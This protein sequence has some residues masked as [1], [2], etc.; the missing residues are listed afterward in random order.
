[1]MGDR[2]V[3]VTKIRDRLYQCEVSV[4]L[5]LAKVYKEKEKP[6]DRFK[7]LKIL[8]DVIELTAKDADEG[9]AALETMWGVIDKL[10]PVTK[11][12]DPTPVVSS[13]KRE[14]KLSGQI[15]DSKTQMGFVSL[16]RQIETAIAKK[17]TETEII[18]AILKA[19]QPGSN[20]RSY[21][22]CRRDIDLAQV[23]QIIRAHY[24]EKNATELYQELSNVTQLSKEDPTE[25][26]MRALGLRQK[27][28]FASS[29]KGSGLT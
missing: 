17:Y 10:D 4:L 16:I 7:A 11:S 18:E 12:K 28:L 22:K 23:K 6:D 27:V 15:G 2:F 29:E 21:L 20:L 13:W 9:V 25:F 14:L 24:K 19:I 5:K 1:M 3:I 8:E 26:L